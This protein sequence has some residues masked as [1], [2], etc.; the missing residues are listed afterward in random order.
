MK[1]IW[2]LNSKL[3][4]SANFIFQQ[5]N[6]EE[7]GIKRPRQWYSLFENQMESFSD[8]SPF[9][10]IKYRRDKNPDEKSS[11]SNR[12]TRVTIGSSNDIYNTFPLKIY[13]IQTD[14][15]TKRSSHIQPYDA[16]LIMYR[17]TTP[18][19]HVPWWFQ[20]PQPQQSAAQYTN[21]YTAR[22]LFPYT[23]YMHLHPRHIHKY[24][25]RVSSAHGEHDRG[26]RSIPVFMH[27]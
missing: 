10:I 12:S 11:V 19:H 27:Q 18:T 26:D 6:E 13:T 1:L 5:Y 2:T 4:S 3:W 8:F 14:H 22:L 15:A 23:N 20:D 17:G 16:N 7:K 24:V 9:R 25:R 21:R